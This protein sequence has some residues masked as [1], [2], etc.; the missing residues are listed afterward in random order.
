ME[1]KNL[2]SFCKA[3]DTV[4]RTKQPPTDLEKIFS[5]PISGRGLISN[6]YKELRTP[7]NQIILFTKWV[8]E[9]NKEFSTK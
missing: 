1:P 8:T 7:D 4:N 5:N 2:Q 6:I 3:K 9:L